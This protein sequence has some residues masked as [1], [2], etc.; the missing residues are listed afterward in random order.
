[1]AADPDPYLTRSGEIT[2][3]CR[4]LDQIIARAEA[5]KAA[6]LGERVD[7]LLDAVP[8]GSAGYEAAE[9]SMFAEISAALHIT[10][11]AAARSLGIGW[12]LQK[13]FP[14]TRAALE[15]GSISARHAAVIIAAAAAFDLADID[16]HERFEG[17][18]VPYAKAETPP[19]TEAFA[20]SVAAAVAPETVVERHRRARGDRRITVTDVD[21]GMSLFAILM[22]T[23]L[24]HAAYDRATA[25]AKQIKLTRAAED[26]GAFHGPSAPQPGQELTDKE[27]ERLAG[28]ESILEDLGE[29]PTDDRTLDEIRADIATDLLLAARTDSLAEAGIDAIHATVQVTIAATTLIGSD[30]RPAEHDGH[31]P[32]HPDL[33]RYLAGGAEHWERL[34]LDPTGM[35]TRTDSYAPT[36]RMRRYLRARDRHCRFPGCRMPAHLC[37]ID[38]NHDHAKGGPTDLCNLCCLC[39]GHHSLKHPDHDVRWRWT[40]VQHPGGIVIW[41][42]PDGR[43]YADTPPP[44]VQFV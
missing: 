15:A 9:R 16:A 19:R 25:I 39:A 33:A 20:K 40:A 6:L 2:D 11:G 23:P 34:F 36:E 35:L 37:E 12:A 8:P 41:T 44:R 14:Q 17:H 1:M 28:F 22:P 42:S 21:D 3:Q 24:A 38:H 26:C 18:V 27:N 43:V 32:I 7:L 30:D 5:D 10:R 31:G 13:R 29:S 4:A